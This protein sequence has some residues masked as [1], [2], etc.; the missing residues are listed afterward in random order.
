MAACWL[1]GENLAS[2]CLPLS[3]HLITNAVAT[4]LN[5]EHFATPWPQF[6]EHLVNPCAGNNCRILWPLQACWR[7]SK[8]YKTHVM[9]NQICFNPLKIKQI[10]FGIIFTLHYICLRCVNVQCQQKREAS[11]FGKYVVWAHSRVKF[12][13]FDSSWSLQLV[14]IKKR[15]IIL[16]IFCFWSQGNVLRFLHTV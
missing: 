14:A 3:H 4:T 7:E 8:E 9:G 13:T 11:H 1:I 2:T 16:D 15:Q 12:K 6:G 10:L 5:S